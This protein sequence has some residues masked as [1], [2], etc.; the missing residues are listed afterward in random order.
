MLWPMSD[1]TLTAEQPYA[2]AGQPVRIRATLHNHGR[3]AQDNLILGIAINDEPIPGVRVEHL[4]P[5]GTTTV[6][7]EIVLADPGYP[8]IS[9]SLPQGDP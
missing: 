6:E 5:G 7:H 2:I 4:P 8:A 9:V 1:E 3:S